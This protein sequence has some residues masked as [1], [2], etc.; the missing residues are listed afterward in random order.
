MAI[1]KTFAFKIK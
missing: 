1:A